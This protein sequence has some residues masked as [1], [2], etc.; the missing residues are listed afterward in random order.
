MYDRLVALLSE[1]GIDSSGVTPQS[2]F[3]D[4]EMD[5]LSMT[6]LAVNAFEAT[7]VLVDSLTLEVTLAEAAEKFAGAAEPQKA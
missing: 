1:I 5:S 3:R 2:T 4:L 6:E 7:G